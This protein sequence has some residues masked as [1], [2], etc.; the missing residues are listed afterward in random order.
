MFFW[1]D[2][3]VFF[4]GMPLRNGHVPAG[5]HSNL[6]PDKPL[7]VNVTENMMEYPDEKNSL[8]GDRR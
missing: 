2:C 4:S 1:V 7:H 8:F 6:S 5:Q 3:S